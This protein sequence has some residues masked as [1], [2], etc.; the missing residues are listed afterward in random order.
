MTRPRP[1][2]RV[3]AALG[4]W[5]GTSLESTNSEKG[6]VPWAK[7]RLWRIHFEWI[8]LKHAWATTSMRIRIIASSAPSLLKERTKF[9]QLWTDWYNHFIRTKSDTNYQWACSSEG[10]WLLVNSAVTYF[11]SHPS[12]CQSL[13]RLCFQKKRSLQFQVS[14]WEILRTC[15]QVKC[16]GR[17]CYNL[18]GIF[19]SHNSLLLGETCLNNGVSNTCRALWLEENPGYQLR[20][21]SPTQKTASARSDF[22]FPWQLWRMWEPSQWAGT[23]SAWKCTIVTQWEFFTLAGLHDTMQWCNCPCI[24]AQRIQ[25]KGTMQASSRLPIPWFQE[26][27]TTW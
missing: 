24:C 6:H 1:P 9:D 27:A 26:I 4:I 5:S 10:M 3:P 12:K 20:R 8:N 7:G 16:M 2:W 21:L 11:L 17:Q 19:S 15:A 13:E 18:N 23:G 22:S 25:S 14:I